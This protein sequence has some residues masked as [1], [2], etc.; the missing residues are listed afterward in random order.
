MSSSLKVLAG[1]LIGTIGSMFATILWE[2]KLCARWHTNNPIDSTLS[3]LGEGI[4]VRRIFVLGLALWSLASFIYIVLRI[5]RN[6]DGKLE[7][8]I[9]AI[10]PT[11]PSDDKRGTKKDT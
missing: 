5:K 7:G 6:P 2:S 1:I 8:V 10:G 11:V 9:E 3:W 4:G